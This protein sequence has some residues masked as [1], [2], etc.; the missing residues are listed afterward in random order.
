M[1]VLVTKKMLTFQGAASSQT[2]HVR[3]GTH[4]HACMFPAGGTL[5]FTATLTPPKPPSLCT[6]SRNGKLSKAGKH[7]ARSTGSSLPCGSLGRQWLHTCRLQGPFA[8]PSLRGEQRHRGSSRVAPCSGTPPPEHARM[9]VAKGRPSGEVWFA[10]MMHSTW[11]KRR[12]ERS[13]HE[14]RSLHGAA[15]W[16]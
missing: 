16:Q 5:D 15:P 8:L 13:V 11:R 10:L 7:R 6:S 14:Q 3:R 9:A 4:H 2:R 12:I 1:G